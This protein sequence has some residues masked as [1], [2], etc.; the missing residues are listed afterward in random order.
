MGLIRLIFLISFLASSI[1]AN[2]FIINRDNSNA[3]FSIKYYK[4]KKLEANF[5]DIYARINYDENLNSLKDISGEIYLNSLNANSE[6]LR[7]LILSEKILDEALYP[8]IKFTASKIDENKVYGNLQIKD[9][10][11]NI[12]LKLIDSG[13]FLDTLYLNLQGTLKRSH[14]DL[15]WDELFSN[16]SSAVAD[17]IEVNINIEARKIEDIKLIRIKEIIKKKK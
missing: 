6:N 16:G 5:S 2:S 10:V 15:S 7:N 14:F 9:V 11:K 3:E 4:D 17:E 13:I 12:E 8:T 1:F